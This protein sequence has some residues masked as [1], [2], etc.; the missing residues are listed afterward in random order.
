MVE[1]LDLA[2]VTLKE[3]SRKQGDSV[4]KVPEYGG[5]DEWDPNGG[6]HSFTITNVPAKS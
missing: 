1:W 5:P 6:I 2:S 3:R 4:E